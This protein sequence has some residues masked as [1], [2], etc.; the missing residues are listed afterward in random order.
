MTIRKRVGGGESPGERPVW[1]SAVSSVVLLVLALVSLLAGALFALFTA[2][3]VLPGLWF[4]AGTFTVVGL[5]L[6]L[7]S[8]V[9]VHI[10]DQGLTIMYGPL[11]RPVQRLALA[12]IDSVRVENRR[13]AEVG[14]WGYRG[15]P[16]KATIMLRGGEC[17]VV[18]YRSGREVGISVDDA[19]RGAALLNA[20][21]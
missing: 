17:L 4:T 10:S 16:G 5:T 13:P 14:G 11:R 12:E 18:R 2:I 19:E 6:L 8:S 21:R 20:M 1:S 15:L 7:F 3:D 9:R